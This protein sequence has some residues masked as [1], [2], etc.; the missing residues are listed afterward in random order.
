MQT[1]FFKKTSVIDNISLSPM[2]QMKLP[3]PSSECSIHHAW[4]C[5]VP[6]SM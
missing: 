2:I 5:F 6:K 4:Y 1:I 3:I